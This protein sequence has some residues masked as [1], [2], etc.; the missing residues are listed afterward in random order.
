MHPPNIA[1]CWTPFCPEH[2]FAR[3][4]FPSQGIFLAVELLCVRGCGCGVSKTAVS[5]HSHRLFEVRHRQ[6]CENPRRH[7]RH[8]FAVGST[9]ADSKFFE[10]PKSSVRKIMKMNDEV[11]NV[12]AV[13]HISYVIHTCRRVDVYD[14]DINTHKHIESYSIHSCLIFPISMTY[15]PM[16]YTDIGCCRADN[17]VGGALHRRPGGSQPS[18][19][20]R[21]QA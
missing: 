8:C 5:K 11:A 10:I 1:N 3:Y 20:R 14:I 13:S 16:L 4:W 6:A 19:L 21:E 18:D 2:P 15:L 7:C 9:M 17:Q 12:S